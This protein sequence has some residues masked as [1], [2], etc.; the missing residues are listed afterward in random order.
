MKFHHHISIFMANI[1]WLKRSFYFHLSLIWNYSFI[2]VDNSLNGG[3]VSFLWLPTTVGTFIWFADNAPLLFIHMNNLYKI[4]E[5]QKRKMWIQCAFSI[6]YTSSALF[7][8]NEIDINRCEEWIMIY[9]CN[10]ATIILI[11][12][13]IRVTFR[14]EYVC[15]LIN[16]SFKT[17]I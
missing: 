3:I 9:V 15:L 12:N 16:K 17:S 6:E 8:V 5:F 10:S 13:R 14:S 11:F 7:D 2:F 4:S 1:T